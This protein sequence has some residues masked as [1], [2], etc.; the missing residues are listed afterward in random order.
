MDA[1]SFACKRSLR[2]TLDADTYVKESISELFQLLNE[3]DVFFTHLDWV[4]Q[5]NGRNTGIHGLRVPDAVNSGVFGFQK[6]AKSLALMGSKW[7]R[8]CELHNFE[9]NEQA[10]IT[11]WVRDP[12]KHLDGIKWR[13]VDNVRYNATR[14]MWLVMHSHGFWNKAKILHFRQTEYFQQL[15]DG[16]MSVDDLLNLELLEK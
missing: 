16:D 12:E 13:L 8:D 15:L 14:R 4:K 6:N 7:Q 3:Y 10:I 2:P 9:K 1:K 11:T 5:V